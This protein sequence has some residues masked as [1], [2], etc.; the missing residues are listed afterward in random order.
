MVKCVLKYFYTFKLNLLFYNCILFYVL[1]FI[2]V[3]TIF[4]ILN[5]T[6]I[7]ILNLTV[8][9]HMI[10]LCST[11][12]IHIIILTVLKFGQSHCFIV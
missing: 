11:H 1:Y 7:C 4:I 10:V 12:I 2:F 6:I 3:N 8:I 9:S 5:I